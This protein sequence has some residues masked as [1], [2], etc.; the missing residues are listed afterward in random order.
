MLTAPRRGSRRR[1]R[2]SPPSASSSQSRPRPERDPARSSSP[3]SA[4]VIPS[5][6]RFTSPTWRRPLVSLLVSRFRL[7][8]LLLVSILLYLQ[9]FQRPQPQLQ[10]QLMLFENVASMLAAGVSTLDLLPVALRNA[11]NVPTSMQS[12]PPPPPLPHLLLLP[13]ELVWSCQPCRPT[14][15]TSS[16]GP[17]ASTSRSSPWHS[18]WP[19]A[20]S[21]STACSV[22]SPT[23]PSSSC[24]S[25]R[26]NATAIWK[27][28]TP[29]PC[30]S[31]PPFGTSSQSILS[32]N[33]ATCMF[34]FNSSL[35]NSFA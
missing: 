6:R 16:H 13:L 27:T 26:R 23:G 15:S 17:S 34:I 30:L 19:S 35:L 25:R 3:Q 10:Q 11:L 9:L 31:S 2:T 24:T 1:P 32:P 21:S 14:G 12:R 5:D 22:S 18:C 20:A 8:L 28:P 4:P 33:T 29:P 7:C